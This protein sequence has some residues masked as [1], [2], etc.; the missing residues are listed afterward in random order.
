MTQTKLNP[1]QNKILK[2]M[3]RHMEEPLSYRDLARDRTEELT[4]SSHLL[5]S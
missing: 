1:I 2:L 5:P 3:E 4:D